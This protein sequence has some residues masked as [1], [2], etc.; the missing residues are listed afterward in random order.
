MIPQLD[1][2]CAY[3]CGN[4]ITESNFRFENDLEFSMKRKWKHKSSAMKQQKPVPRKIHMWARARICAHY[5]G[6]YGNEFVSKI[7]ASTL[8][9][10]G[11][12]C[13][14]VHS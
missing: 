14:C 10:L 6:M 9:V 11:I 13:V 1:D 8:C 4:Y 2:I 5:Y 3:F 7:H 12:V